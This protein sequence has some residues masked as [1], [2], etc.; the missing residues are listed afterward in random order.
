MNCLP[1]QE[2]PIHSLSHAPG[3]PKICTEHLPWLIGSPSTRTARFKFWINTLNRSSKLDHILANT[4]PDI[5]NNNN[6]L[7]R[8]LPIG[9]L[10]NFH[11]TSKKANFFEEDFSCLEWLDNQLKGSVVYV[12]F[13]SW[14]SPIGEAK[15]KSLAMALKAARRP[16]IWVLGQSWRDGLP[17]RYFDEIKE[18]GKIVSWAPQMEILQHEAVGFYLTHCGWNSTV[19]A[20]QCRKSMLCFPVAGD[21][22]LNCAYI[23]NTW[24]IGVRLNGLEEHDVVEGFAKLTMDLDGMNQRIMALNDRFMGFS[25]N[26]YKSMN[27]LKEFIHDLKH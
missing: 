25:A 6:D 20:I 14:V 5:E 2:G 24:R 8:I 7:P 15:V 13:G 10:I 21:Q 3:Q 26:C 27:N 11:V 23:V 19:E 18:R 12:S 4:F 1:L 22:F 9:H 16:F 17:G